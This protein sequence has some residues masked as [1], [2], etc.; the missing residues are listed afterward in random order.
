MRPRLVTLTTD[1][2]A[3]YA[4]QMKGV[5]S[6]FV[7]A[8][9]VVDLAHDLTPHGVLEAAFLLRQMAI[10]FPPGTVHVAVV[11]PGVGGR[12][13]PVA[14]RLEDGSIVVGPDNGVLAPLAAHLGVVECVRLRPE[15]VTPGSPP[16]ATFEGRDLFAPAAGRLA[17]GTP[18]A[19]LGVPWHLRRLAIPTGSR[20][21]SGALGEVLHVDR[22]GNVITSLPSE[23]RPPLDTTVR[24]RVGGRRPTLA[25]TVRTYEPLGV[26]ELGLLTSSFGRLELGVREGRAADRLRAA[27][28]TTLSL[29]WSPGGP[30]RPPVVPPAGRRGASGP[31]NAGIRLRSFRLGDHAAVR[32]LWELSGLS[33]DPSDSRQEIART[34]RRDPDL[35]L[36]AV[37]GGRVV[38]AVLGRFDG[39]RGWVNHLAVAPASQSD[40]IG[41]RLLDELE[42]RL[43]RRGCRKINL[44]LVPPNPRALAFYRRAGYRTRE[45]L[46]LQKVLR[47]ADAGGPATHK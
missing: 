8:G 29:S 9:H 36:V 22:F 41:R 13:A 44:H 40:G 43:R 19:R 31:G 33:L 37:R 3:A 42:R 24:V 16:S 47:D 45:L 17:T 34:V 6:R 39:R 18:L 11:D 23:W 25:R 21:R 10:G 12:R 5:L 14:A 30:S 28:G 35:F 7:P 26:G 20:R 38:G 2:G 27:P 15:L 4:A 46:F 1:V 32:R